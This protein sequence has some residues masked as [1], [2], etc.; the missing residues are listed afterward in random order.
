MKTAKQMAEDAFV[1]LAT[2]N[3]YWFKPDQFRA[4]C[5]QLCKEQREICAD[6][7]DYWTD[8]DGKFYIDHDSI[9]NATMPEL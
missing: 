1:P 6:N 9:R 2:T 3:M 8:S 5:E 4:F 7:A